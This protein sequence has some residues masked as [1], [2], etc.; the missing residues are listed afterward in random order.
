MTAITDGLEGGHR[1][2]DIKNLRKVKKLALSL[3]LYEQ[4]DKAQ[5]SAVLEVFGNIEELSLVLDHFQDGTDEEEL[6]IPDELVDY[7]ETQMA[8]LQFNKSPWDGHADVPGTILVDTW[9]AGIDI[10]ALREIR[11]RDIACFDSFPWKIPAI[12][13]RVVISKSRM[14]RL[15]KDR[16]M[17]ENKVAQFREEKEC[18]KIPGWEVSLRTLGEECEIE[19]QIDAESVASGTFEDGSEVWIMTKKD[20]SDFDR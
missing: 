11:D 15:E 12:E 2:M 5:L 1:I 3:D 18:M 20:F 10:A 8:Y 16:K 6:L 19:F 17:C 4:V 13:P 7:E 9:R 14:E